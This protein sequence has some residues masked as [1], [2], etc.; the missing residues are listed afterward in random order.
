MLNGVTVTIDG[1]DNMVD[2]MFDV[3]E[4]KTLPV[5]VTTNYLTISDGYIP[6]QAPEVSKDMVTLPA[7][8]VSGQRWATLHRRGDLLRRAGQ[9]GHPGNAAAVL[10]L[11]RHGSEL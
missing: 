6:L 9:L 3:V 1:S 10:H 4:E 11:R 5:T 2:V 8:A 7:P